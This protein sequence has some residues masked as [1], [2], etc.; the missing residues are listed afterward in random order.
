M[1][2]RREKEEDEEKNKPYPQ[3][4]QYKR[5]R[6]KSLWQQNEHPKK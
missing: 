5:R 2:E 3:L 1:T 6:G 4:P